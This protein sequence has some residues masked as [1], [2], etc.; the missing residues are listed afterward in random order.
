VRLRTKQGF[1]LIEVLV[2]ILILAGGSGYILQAL[3]KSAQVQKKVEDG[4]KLYPSL[5]MQLA[6]SHMRISTDKNPFK[7]SQ[8]T[9]TE[10][11]VQFQWVSSNQFHNPLEAKAPKESLGASVL[12]ER[13][14]TVGEADQKSAN[15]LSLVT[16]VR[17]EI[18]GNSNA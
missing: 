10:D 4:I 5:A 14:L 2:S 1:T 16:L 18:P 7:D 3:A 13:N 9:F 6:K 11:N 17:A 15:R 12:L 8:G